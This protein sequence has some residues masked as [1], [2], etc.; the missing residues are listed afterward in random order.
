MLFNWGC[1]SENNHPSKK[2]QFD[3]VNDISFTMTFII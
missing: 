1:F 2:I 3:I